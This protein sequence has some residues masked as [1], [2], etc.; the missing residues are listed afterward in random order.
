MPSRRRPEA[1]SRAR[2]ARVL[3]VGLWLA[4][5]AAGAAQR[6]DARGYLTTPLELSIISQKADEGVEPYAAARADVLAIAAEP[7][8]WGFSAHETCPTAETPGWNDNSRGTR[9][10]YANAL[11]YHL[12]GSASYAQVVRTRLEAAMSQVLDFAPVCDTNLGWGGAELVASADLIEDYWEGLSCTGPL[13]ATPGNPTLGSGPCKPLFQNWLA[14]NVYPVVSQMATASQNNRG[15]AG[16]NTLAHVADY[17]WDRSDVLLVHHNPSRINSGLDQ[18]FTP[19][20][21]FAHARQLALDRM[22][23]YSIDLGVSSCDYLGGTFQTSEYP[24]V[25]SQIT[26]GGTIP[27]DAR[28]DEYCNIPFYDGSYQNYPQ[29][30][31][32]HNVQQCELLLRRGDRSCYDNL[33]SSDLPGYP[34]LG[35]DDVLRTTHLEPG[36]GSIERAIEAILIISQTEWRHDPALEVALNY[37]RHYGGSEGIGSWRY[38]IDDRSECSTDLCLTTL[39]HGLAFEFP[40]KAVDAPPGGEAQLVDV[41]LTTGAPRVPLEY[42]ACAEPTG[43]LNAVREVETIAGL[44]YGQ[45]RLYGIELAAS[46]SE[47]HLVELAPSVCAVGSRVGTAAVGFSGLESLAACTGG[48]LFSADWDAASGRS[49]LVRIDPAT[50]VGALVSS[51]LMAQD[52]R[53]VGL[54]CT[55]DG[56]ILWALTSGEGARPAELLTVDPATGVETVIGPTGTAAGALQALELDRGSPSTRLIAAGTAIYTL[57]PATGT[58]TLLGGSFGGVRALA[59]PHPSSGPDWDNDGWTDA[60]DNCTV[61]SNSAQTDVDADGFGNAC[62]GDFTNNGMVGLQD[63]SIMRRVFGSAAG[64]P[65]FDPIADMDGDGIVDIIDFARWLSGFGDPPG[66]SG[67]ACA[68]TIPCP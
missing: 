4:C 28:R 22:N 45:A 42:G 61:A 67:L 58:A 11:A 56:S 2:A 65:G 19:A 9:S 16:T 57:D 18:L 64:S 60:A 44:A 52:L 7:W 66:P 62:D 27:E 59:M 6:P 40:L 47:A 15:A 24:P 39:T 1:P 20:Q 51:H 36:R 13:T 41:S 3:A 8:V 10:I 53:I 48:P 30:H 12:T 38:E 25:K 55:S 54:S 37:Y 46:G 21:A 26:P 14:K 33:D 31:I 23:G 29:G 49:R 43:S 35:P 17:L 50:G 34:V 32:G 63:F 68:G 5:G